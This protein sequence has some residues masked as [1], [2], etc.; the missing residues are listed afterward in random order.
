MA[1][2]TS[3]GSRPVPRLSRSAKFS[4]PPRPPDL[5]RRPRLLNPLHEHIHRK[6]IL[7]SAAAGYG[8]SSLLADFVHDTDYPVAWLHLDEADHDLAALA[9]DLAL[10]LQ[11]AFPAFQSRLPTLAAQPGTT[12]A[13]LAATLNREIETA[14][15]DYFI[16]AL[17]DFHLLDEAAPVVTFFDALL[18]DLPEQAHVLVAGRTRPP[19]RI[20]PLAARGQIF[21]LGEEHLRF[22][23][24]E[25]RDLL[26]LRNQLA[27]PEAEAEKLV[28]NTEGWITGILLT[29]HLMW[30][31]LMASLIQARQSE[32][33]LYDYLAEEVLDQQPEPLRPFLLESAVLPEMEPA[34][35]DEVLGRSDS[36][37]L[38][39]QAEA[40][41][42]FISVVGNDFRAYQYH[43]LFRD[44]LIARLRAHDPERL[45]RLQARAA[46]WYAAHGMAEAAVTFYV[47]AG[48]LA[49][50]AEVVEANAQE[51]R[52]IGR[53]ATLRRWAEQL[54]VMAYDVPRLYLSL[55]K[56]DTDADQLKAA[57]AELDIAAA[58]FA[59]RNSAVGNLEVEI[60]R[61]WILIRQ[62]DFQRALAI[63]QAS[64]PRA[65]A[66]QL[67]DSTAHALRY[68]GVCQ[69]NLGRL[70]EAEE[71]LQQAAQLLQDQPHP[72]DLAWTLSD[73]ALVLRARGQTTR[74]ARAQQQSLAILRERSAAFP[75]SIALNNIGWDLHML[76]QYEA[77]LETYGEALTWARQ[78]GSSR[79]EALIL[80][81]RADVYADLDDRAAAADLCRQAMAKVEQVGDWGLAAYLYRAMARLDRW[82]GNF[83]SALEWLRRAAMAAGQ[84]K[85]Q[86]PLAHLEGLR[87]I[88]LF[89]MGHTQDGRQVLDQACSDLEQAGVLVD[90]AQTLLSRACAEFH[91]G[92]PEAAA[93]ESAGHWAAG[94]PALGAHGGHRR[95]ENPIGD[96]RPAPAQ[97]RGG[98][99]GLRV[100]PGPDLD[101]GGGDFAGGVGFIAAARAALLFDRPGADPPRSSP[102]NFLAGHARGPRLR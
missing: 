11:R 1:S 41:R 47:M 100:R 52:A 59:R 33:P 62:G 35:C 22:T 67:V 73:L 68:V 61:S 34:V 28:A 69:F 84:G 83:V 17:D 85:G 91:A 94:S 30:Q 3:A 31:G 26:Q 45:R 95:N 20:V 93:P 74:A 82:A 88:I 16:L 102:A 2:T 40:R 49:R 50:A 25:V 44:F 71:H 57:E 97:A 42:L 37:L 13:A 78:A 38:L 24:A 9:A 99:P 65:R 12:A 18:E 48:H 81:G 19:L 64:A 77:A 75:L 8:K 43:H 39:R 66:L 7:I 36:A 14:L 89:E 15:D 58:G 79:S 46:D 54:A 55:A 70:A 21:G 80:A 23:P 29:T 32:A 51:M 76:G 60:Q 92:D 87:G 72:Y 53:H 98:S 4:I 5:L 96:V 56:A 86:A 90:L 6:L 10:A 63:A 27:L 101:Q